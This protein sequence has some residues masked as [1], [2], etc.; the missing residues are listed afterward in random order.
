GQYSWITSRLDW[1]WARTCCSWDGGAHEFDLSHRAGIAV[2]MVLAPRK[3][4][5]PILGCIPVSARPVFSPSDINVRA[6]G[7][8]QRFQRFQ[9]NCPFSRA[10]TGM[11]PRYSPKFRMSPFSRRT[12]AAFHG[13]FESFNNLRIASDMSGLAAPASHTSVV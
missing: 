2:T 6:R 10:I 11:H 8:F 4:Q 1:E 3:K 7:F 5:S 12:R 9:E 13:D